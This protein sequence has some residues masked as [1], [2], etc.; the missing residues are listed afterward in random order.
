MKIY[1]LLEFGLN[2][3]LGHLAR[4]SNLANHLK[5]ISIESGLIT[6][7]NSF[8]NH[9]KNIESELLKPFAHDIN[10]FTSLEDQNQANYEKLIQYINIVGSISDITRISEYN[11]VFLSTPHKQHGCDGPNSITI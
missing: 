7:F 10:N 3:G 11:N 6:T 5:K 9:K 2:H 1:F 8:D 4:C